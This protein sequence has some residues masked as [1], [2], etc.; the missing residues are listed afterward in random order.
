VVSRSAGARVRVHRLRQFEHAAV[1]ET[2]GDAGCPETMIADRRVDSGGEAVE[3]H[4]QRFQPELGRAARSAAIGFSPSPKNRS[5]PMPFDATPEL[6]IEARI[7]DKALDILGPNGEKWLQGKLADK[8]GN[9]CMLGAI[10]LAR[11]RLK[12]KGDSTEDHLLRVLQRDFEQTVPCIEEFNEHGA[13][14]F[15]PRPQKR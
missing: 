2:G 14:R 7:I 6:P 13:R 10:R 4:R 9:H 5:L 1:R 11:R 15:R 3:D 8:H 12:T